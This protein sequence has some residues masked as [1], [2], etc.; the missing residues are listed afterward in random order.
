MPP[1]RRRA[2]ATLAALG[3]IATIAAPAD[4]R[5]LTPRAATYVDVA[6]P[7]VNFADAASVSVD[8]SPVRRALLRFTVPAGTRMSTLRL[9]ALTPARHRVTIRASGCAWNAATVT[10]RNRPRTGKALVTKAKITR[11]WNSFRLPAGA[12]RTGAT[13]LPPGHHRR[14]RAH[15][16]PGAGR[17]PFAAARR[18]AR[19]GRRA[20][21][22]SRR[23][24]SRRRPRRR[25]A[26]ARPGPRPCR[27]RRPATAP[28]R[29]ARGPAPAAR[30]P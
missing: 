25:P 5:T 17:R 16:L 19:Q 20:R 27:R 13:T 12:Q 6:R 2:A 15:P 7:S 26:R 30:S 3:A 23:R 29:P 21:R 24:R 1:V 8:G 10:A 4:A 22:R 28:R 18:H 9:Y 14:P 11:G